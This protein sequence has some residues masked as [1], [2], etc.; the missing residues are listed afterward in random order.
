M[1]VARRT[2]PQIKAEVIR[3][4]KGIDASGFDTRVEQWIYQALLD[5]STTLHHF[6]LDTATTVTLS[7]ASNA[8]PLPAGTF[9]VVGAPQLLEPGT[10]AIDGPLLYQDFRFLESS[11]TGL[12][13]RPSKW[14]RFSS[15]F[16]TDLLPRVPYT[17]NLFT[18][19][20]PPA[21]DFSV[22]LSAV[23]PLGPETDEYVMARALALAWPEIDRP[24]LGAEQDKKLATW[25]QNQVRPPLAQ[26]FLT[27]MKE[28]L[29][30]GGTFGG[31]QG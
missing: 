2:W 12:A 30:S 14:S 22:A 11:Y 23:S 25:V 31:A 16:Y 13:G 19:V 20:Y 5:L 28:Q 24:D 15:S 7:T 8:V 18:Y 6:E 26:V 29:T 10:G 4:L 9:I 21:P 17:V 27:E 3:R 1:P